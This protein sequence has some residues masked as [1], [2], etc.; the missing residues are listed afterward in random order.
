MSEQDINRQEAVLKKV[1]DRL[2]RFDSDEDADS[3]FI[4]GSVV[5]VKEMGRINAF[6]T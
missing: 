2:F 4:N 3:D 1:K 6:K 5:S